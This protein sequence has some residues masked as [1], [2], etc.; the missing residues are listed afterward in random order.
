M[1][2]AVIDVAA[3]SGGALSVLRDFLSYL[4]KE[5]NGRD[6]FYVFVSKEVDIKNECIHY[7]L[8]PEIRLLY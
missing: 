7:V 3:E 6:E 4:V 8:K 5:Y 2:I 1:R